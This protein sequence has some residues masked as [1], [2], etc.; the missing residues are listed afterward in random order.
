MEDLQSI[1]ASSLMI[2]N[3]CLLSM[4]KRVRDST[5]ALTLLDNENHRAAPYRERL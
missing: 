5:T 2:R 1:L 4:S 3:E